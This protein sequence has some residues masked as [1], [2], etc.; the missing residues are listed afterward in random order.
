MHSIDTCNG[1]ALK[2]H[3]SYLAFKGKLCYVK[4]HSGTKRKKGKPFKI[5]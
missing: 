2:G 5:T 1:D 4:M 3:F